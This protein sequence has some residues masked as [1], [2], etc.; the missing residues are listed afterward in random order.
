MNS[1]IHKDLPTKRTVLS[2][3]RP[4]TKLANLNS[5]TVI[6]STMYSIDLSEVLLLFSGKR[7]DSE[8]FHPSRLI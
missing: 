6:I 4:S 1:V 3:C 5:L 7:L 2:N 8:D